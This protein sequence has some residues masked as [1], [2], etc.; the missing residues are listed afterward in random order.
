MKWPMEAGATVQN[1]N[2]VGISANNYFSNPSFNFTYDWFFVSNY[3]SPEPTIYVGEEQSVRTIAWQTV[4]LSS[5]NSTSI[6]F[7][8][9]TT[10]FLYGNYTIG[11]YAMPVLGETNT[12]DNNRT[13]GF[14][15]VAGQ[16]DLTG[17]TPNPYDFMPDGYDHI[18][19]VSVVA[20]S[21]GQK[22]P[23]PPANC[24]VSG[25]T[26]GVPDGKIDISDVALVA[27]NYGHFYPYPI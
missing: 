25:T 7:P 17:G 18:E 19:D 15:F 27:K 9:N 2:K 1:T 26:I 3:V 23:P 16:G 11:A 14:V 20:K 10:G 22:V 24:D 12:A 6:T 13:G 5:G 4:T 8:W 21:F